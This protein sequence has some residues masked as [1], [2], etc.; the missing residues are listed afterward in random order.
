MDIYIKLPY[1]P[2]T[3]KTQSDMRTILHETY[4][5]GRKNPP[6]QTATEFYKKIAMVFLY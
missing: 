2:R 4:L 1:I 5:L 6:I 3:S